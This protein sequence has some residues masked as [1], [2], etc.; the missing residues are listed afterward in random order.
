MTSYFNIG[1]IVS[2]HGLSGELIIEH[3]LGKKTALSGV[4][5]LF[6]EEKKGSFIPHFIV[7][8][9]AKSS[10][11]LLVTLEGISTREQ[12]RTFL[13]LPVWLQQA[14]FEKHAAKTAPISLLGFHIIDGECD[15]GPILEVIEQEHQI[16]CTILYKGKEAMIPL[17]EE[18]LLKTD[19]K[20]KKVFVVLP[21]GLLDIYA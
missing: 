17:H 21:E 16:L 11:E 15:L 14:D 10:S 5:A 4:T 12:A 2:A 1:K 6:I 20:N 3:H 8:V 7:T 9:N 19:K 13:N 18:S